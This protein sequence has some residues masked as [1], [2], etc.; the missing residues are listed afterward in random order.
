[1]FVFPYHPP[2]LVSVQFPQGKP[3]GTPSWIDQSRVNKSLG[4]C[5]DGES[6]FDKGVFVA[7]NQSIQSWSSKEE[8]F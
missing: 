7:N 6:A 1:M 4:A 3:Y 8:G 2:G 5:D